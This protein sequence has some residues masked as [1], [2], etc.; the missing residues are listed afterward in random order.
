MLKHPLS[1]VHKLSENQLDALIEAA[2]QILDGPGMTIESAEGC[3]LLADAGCRVR[4]DQRVRFEPDFVL[5]HAAKAPSEWTWHARNPDRSVSVGGDTLLVAPGY[6]SAFVAAASGRRRPAT[7]ED[8]RSFTSLAA[9]ADAIDAMSTV[10]VEPSDVPPERRSV[11]MTHALLTLSDKPIMGSVL[12]ATAAQDSIEMARIVLGDIDEKPAVL[13][14]ININSPL[15]LDITMAEALLEYV[16][17]GQPVLLTPGILMGVSA[18]VTAAGAV[19][20][21]FAELLAGVVLAQ[22]LRPGVPVIIG[23]GGFGADLRAGGSG[24]GRPEQALGTIM[25]AQL[26]RKLGLPFRSS[27]ATTGSMRPDCRSGYERMMTA[28]ASWSA[29][30]HLCLQAAGTLD[31]INSMCYEQFVI[32][33]EVWGYLKRL[34]APVAV[35][36]ESLALDLIAST[37][38]D[39]MAT[40]HTL[41][42]F[43]DELR[44]PRLAP[45][46]T[47]E[48]WLESGGQSA[49]D[50]AADK[51]R[52][53]LANAPPPAL[54]PS[55]ARALDEYRKHQ[56]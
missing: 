25:A 55:V 24:F 16:R 6:G 50:L 48:G 2:L 21:A 36:E 30:T 15:R 52:G 12:G 51:V 35:D 32:D 3:A 34:A 44:T 37:P 4:D 17:A 31:C 11:E 20:Q 33:L 46:D 8:F 56:R 29:G 43:R 47:Y 40:E 49:T 45:P 1:Y 5:H 18:P 41:R 26:A 19:A 22:V 28:L 54:D 23:T 42:H 10:V 39:Y 9:Q 14:L 27:A 13:G 53:M 7:M 38:G